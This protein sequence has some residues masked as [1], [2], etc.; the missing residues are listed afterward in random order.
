[1]KYMTFFFQLILIIFVLSSCTKDK[2]KDKST[3][4]DKKNNP[5]VINPGHSYN[6]AVLNEYF[7]SFGNPDYEFAKQA[8]REFNPAFGIFA[9]YGPS[10]IYKDFVHVG[11]WDRDW[12]STYKNLQGCLRLHFTASAFLL[13]P[14]IS[15]EEAKMAGTCNCPDESTK[16]WLRKTGKTYTWCCPY[17][18]LVFLI[19]ESSTNTVF[20]PASLSSGIGKEMNPRDIAENQLPCFYNNSQ[21]CAQFVINP[22]MLTDMITRQ[23]GLYPGDVNGW[24]DQCSLTKQEVLAMNES[25]FR[26]FEVKQAKSAAEN[27]FEL[28]QK[29][30]VDLLDRA[31]GVD[32]TAVKKK[33]DNGNTP[34]HI[35]SLIGNAEVARILVVAGADINVKNKIGVAP[36]HL[37]S[38]SSPELVKFLLNNQADINLKDDEG[39]TP[40]HWAYKSG[41]TEI[42]SQLISLG[43]DQEIKNK[44]GLKPIECE[45]Y[46]YE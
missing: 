6:V 42:V 33:D 41:N 23:R 40:L 10:T 36:I 14:R 27:I 24:E 17:P 31:V 44:Q 29:G 32:P 39:D 35:A 11:D 43:A 37:A 34:L 5:E 7:R 13:I 12:I 46:G 28:V 9:D 22:G 21:G 8:K 15:H 38:E 3:R 19:H 45:S 1:M 2:T 4:E 20:V 30:D 26:E 16:A 18:Q 25:V